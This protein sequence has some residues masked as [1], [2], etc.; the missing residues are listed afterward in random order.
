MILY[1]FKCFYMILYI[2]QL[3]WTYSQFMSNISKATEHMP[4]FH[5]GLSLNK[6]MIPVQHYGPW[7]EARSVL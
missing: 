7:S 5:R 4:T 2:C 1:D 6:H 3:L